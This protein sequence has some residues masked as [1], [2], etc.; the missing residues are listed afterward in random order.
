MAKINNSSNQDDNNSLSFPSYELIA[1]FDKLK[2]EKDKLKYIKE[3]AL[4][5][6]KAFRSL[7]EILQERLENP[8]K[9][10]PDKSLFLTDTSQVDRVGL[11]NLVDDIRFLL[12][13]KYRTF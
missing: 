9:P 4:S 10:I 12:A 2:T 3:L 6:I 5:E 13:V 7:S 1:N 8:P 11:I